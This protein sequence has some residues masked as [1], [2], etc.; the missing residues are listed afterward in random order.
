MLGAALDVIEYEDMSKDGLDLATMP[1]DF[2][3]LLE[4]D[5]TVLT[6]HVAGWTVES[7]DKL[8]TV[9]AEKIDGELRTFGN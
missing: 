7:R 2:R 3:Y 6:P 1:E 8:G 5:R 4:S 9:L